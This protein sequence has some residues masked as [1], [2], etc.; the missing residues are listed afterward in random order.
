MGGAVGS[1]PVDRGGGKSIGLGML[2]LQ[3]EPL[4]PLLRGRARSLVHVLAQWFL[5]SHGDPRA[6]L[7]L[8]V[9]LSFPEPGSRRR[10]V[11]LRLRWLLSGLLVRP[12]TRSPERKAR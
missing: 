1:A 11:L 5:R 2:R 8:A 6:L 10:L 7:R 9:P 4:F 12:I 3:P